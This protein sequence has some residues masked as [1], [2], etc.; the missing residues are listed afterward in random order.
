[1]GGLATGSSAAVTTNPEIFINENQP[2]VATLG[3]DLGS[4][5]WSIVG[6]DDAA[7]FSINAS[8]ELTFNSA[9][10][11]EN[12][13]DS[14]SN[15]VY[16]VRVKDDAASA[17]S[18][19]FRVT[20]LD[21]N[22]APVVTSGA[23]ASF[24]ENDPVSTV[25]Y[26]A[27]A[28]DQDGDTV[29]LTMTGTDASDFTFD[30]ATGEVTFQSSPDAETKASYSI[31][32]EAS[33]GTLTDTQTVTITINDVNEFPVTFNA[34]TATATAVENQTTTTYSPSTTDAD[35]N[36]SL[37]YSIVGGADQALFTMSG[38]TLS[39]LVAPDYEAPD[40]EFYEVIIEVSDGNTS[41]QQTLT[42][43]VTDANEVP[44]FTSETSVSMPENTTATGYVAV[45]VDE[46]DASLTYSIV[47]GADQALFTLVGG[48]LSFSA[49]P[50]FEAV[51]SNLYV[52]EIQA[53]DGRGG[54]ATQTVTVEVTNEAAPSGLVI[55][56]A[57]GGF[58][59]RVTA[60]DTTAILYYTVEVEVGGAWYSTLSLTGNASIGGLAGTTSY[61]VRVAA[62]ST[63]GV[64]LYVSGAETTLALP[65]GPQGPAG[66]NGADG[67]TGPQGP[68]GT[69]GADGATG[70]Q[71]PAGAKGDT[72]ATG[73][74]GPAGAKGDTGATGPAGADGVLVGF[75]GNVTTLSKAQRATVAKYSKATRAS[76][77]VNVYR[78]SGESLKQ[79]RAR[80]RSI[81]AA[82]TR[83]N[84]GI[85]FSAKYFKTAKPTAC[86]SVR[87]RC[88]V[89]V[90]RS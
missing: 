42:V 75:N 5:S 48:A 17:A 12:P 85:S 16:L 47:G 80:A 15:N 40:D 66:T 70:P 11:F 74:Q 56:P 20:V 30:P 90:F 58:Q 22:D 10:D 63:D 37:T 53:S 88:A 19:Q 71:G 78:G 41:D 29:T 21:V 44:V 3:S 24:D 79:M 61:N 13:S 52:V 46:D 64:G 65:T 69:N 8:G 34:P 31:D 76:V 55:V 27:T 25:V 23:T 26:T 73:P 59:V 60:P 68:A 45:A 50:D 9:P 32:I 57:P 1:V 84:P 89:L 49:A 43:E 14:D 81:K 28:T 62:V 38:S 82:V 4:P 35:A 18:Y 87:N 51:R 7:D 2:T 54:T 83:A 6:G 39:F 67:A 36:E 86:K 33:D 77:R 72:G